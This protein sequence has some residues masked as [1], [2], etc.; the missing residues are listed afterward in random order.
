MFDRLHDSRVRGAAF[1]WL[2]SKVEEHGDVLPRKI[3]AEGSER[4]E[5]RYQRF[6]QRARAS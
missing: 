6:L 4:L 2:S 1:D 3:L 5:V